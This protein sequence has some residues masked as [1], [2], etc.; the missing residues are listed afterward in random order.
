MTSASVASSATP[1]V[2]AGLDHARESS[3]FGDR[4]RRTRAASAGDESIPDAAS[5]LCGT[6][7]RSASRTRQAA[8]PRAE[9]VIA[10]AISS[11]AISRSTR[12]RRSSH[13]T[14]GCQP[15]TI[16]IA[17]WI[18][19]ATSSRRC[20]WAH[21]WITTRS[22][23]SSLSCSIRSGATAMIGAPQP[24]TA[25]ARTRSET[26]RGAN[27]APWPTWLHVRSL[28]STPG[29]N[30]R[31]PVR[32]RRYGPH[33]PGD[34]RAVRTG[35][36]SP[37]RDRRTARVP[38]GL[39]HG[40]EGIDWRAV[41][42][43]LAPD[44]RRKLNERHQRQ[45]QDRKQRCRAD[46]VAGLR[47]RSIQQ[48]E[49]GGRDQGDDRTLPEPVHNSVHERSFTPRLI[50]SSAASAP[51]DRSVHPRARSVPAGPAIHRRAWP[52]GGSR[53]DGGPA[54]RR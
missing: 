38:P 41:G 29:V 42:H 52:P 23:S 25:A 45:D 54:A 51:P 10:T 48:P 19:L 17:N 12:S 30:G 16:R 40:N 20:T 39:R 53:P 22:R 34:A 27:R 6:D 46:H 8:Y 33:T 49:H 36:E 47:R 4:I 32:V 13:H 35:P 26:S 24:S 14:A 37:Q 3:C 5:I 7:G 15:A 43:E 28:T 44:G 18:R 2:A 50:A 11:Q 21:S 31:Q 1:A 9:P